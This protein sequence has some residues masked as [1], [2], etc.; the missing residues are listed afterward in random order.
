MSEL[1]PIYLFADSQM[2]FWKN[3]DQLFLESVKEHITDVSPT[4]AYI[5]ASNGD[6]IEFYEFFLA[7][8]DNIGINDCRLISAFFEQE[9][10]EFLKK[11]DIIL[12][13]GGDVV[14]GWKTFQ[15]VGLDTTIQTRYGEGA[16]LM[17]VSAGAIQLGQC[18]LPEDDLSEGSAFN[19]LRILPFVVG[20]HEENADWENLKQLVSIKSSLHR[21]IGIPAGGGLIY[22]SDLSIEPLRFPLHEFIYTEKEKKIA[23]NLL[24]PAQ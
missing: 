22:H 24:Y 11:A 6:M 9:D 5:G 14:L 12:L 2:L 16:L 21:G 4:A 20:V 17:G 23:D 1:K 13:A 3:D 18:A 8:M 7:A 19:T 10:Q 15:A